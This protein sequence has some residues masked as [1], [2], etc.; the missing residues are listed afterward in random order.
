M[1]VITEEQYRDI[2]KQYNELTEFIIEKTRQL[3][4]IQ[5]GEYPQGYCNETDFEEENNKLMVQFEYYACG[6]SCYDTYYLPLEFLFDESYP[7]KYKIIY[8][9]EKL[10]KTKDKIQKEKDKQ[11]KDKQLKNEHELQEYE[12]LKMKFEPKYY[13]RN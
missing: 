10:Q 7:E 5:Y 13:D 6:E 8:E 11:E 1:N 2:I 3:A 4:L 12:R 9:K